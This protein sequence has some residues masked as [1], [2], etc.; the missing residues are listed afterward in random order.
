MSNKA[1]GVHTL[2]DYTDQNRTHPAPR[3]APDKPQQLASSSSSAR[4]AP[5]T[6]QMFNGV[7]GGTIS[8]GTYTVAGGD[9]ITIPA[10]ATPEQI[11]AFLE[12]A[13]LHQPGANIDMFNNVEN[14]KVTDVKAEVF[15]GRVLNFAM[16]VMQPAAAAGESG[17][18]TGESPGDGRRRGAG[19]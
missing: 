18:K 13:S 14:S 3:T 16:P 17:N 2:I 1:T 7:R 11:T 9:S 19:Q 5:A 10:N 4:D 6:V 8:G 12:A 15:G